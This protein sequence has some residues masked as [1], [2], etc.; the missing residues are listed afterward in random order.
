MSSKLT[1]HYP[2][3]FEEGVCGGTLTPHEGPP[4]SFSASPI[5]E[6][7]IEAIHGAF[8]FR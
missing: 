5:K 7:R 3:A 4:T 8:D 2:V 6:V 1:G